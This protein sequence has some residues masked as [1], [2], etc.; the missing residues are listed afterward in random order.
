M[1]SR[2]FKTIVGDIT[3]PIP[4]NIVINRNPGLTFSKY[5][6]VK[7]PIASGFMPRKDA[8]DITNPIT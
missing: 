8:L 7:K 2:Y 4:T 3:E 5:A 1:V 6:A